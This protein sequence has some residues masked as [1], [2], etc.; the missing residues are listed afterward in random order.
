MSAPSN[1]L[2]R[3]HQVALVIAAASAFV[4]AAAALLLPGF[5]LLQPTLGFAGILA[6]ACALLLAFATPDELWSADA[7]P[8]WRALATSAAALAAVVL[9]AS[10]LSPTPAQTFTFGA[11]GEA[12]GAPTWLAALLVIVIASRQ[13]F[14]PVLHRTVSVAVGLGS[15]S[16]VVGLVEAVGGHQ[17]TGGF[18]NGDYLGMI[19]LLLVPLALVSSRLAVGARR[20]L[21][22]AAAVLMSLAA[23]AG[24]SSAV[25]VALVAE[26][27]ALALFAPQLFGQAALARRAGFV[28]L[29]I[30]LGLGVALTVTTFTAPYLGISA[31]VRDTFTGPTVQ[32][33]LEM[34]RTAY[35]AWLT[36]P[37]LGFGPDG[38]QFAS[39][40]AATLTL[41]RLE[42]APY[43]GISGLLRDPHSLPLM[44]LVS[45]GAIGA[46]A[47]IA[48]AV[49]WGRAALAGGVSSART[50]YVISAVAFGACMFVM[51]WNDRFSALPALVA[52]LALAPLARPATAEKTDSAQQAAAP[53]RQR[54]RLAARLLAGVAALL[55]VTAVAGDML[56]TLGAAA[57]TPASGLPM[58]RAAQAIQPTRAYVR[59]AVLYKEGQGL[60]AGAV[61]FEAY[62]RDVD[63][64]RSLEG[65]GV[66]LALLAQ[67][68]LDLYGLK[69]DP[70]VLAWARDRVDRALVLAPQ[71]PDA[72][73]E[74]AHLAAV[75]ADP[76]TAE[77]L[78]AELADSNVQR[79]RMLLYEYY[80]AVAAGRTADAQKVRA[81][82]TAAAPELTPLL[83]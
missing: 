58:L 2:S 35:D 12:M 60:A 63:A 13:R 4:P 61:S 47:V 52:G 59:Y 10:A 82:L 68:A 38:M 20:S 42:S 28:G 50:A 67:P 81:T 1:A 25:I 65:N 3:R 48:F 23:V 26:W 30:S 24:T 8:A 37:V 76:Q 34:W 56:A 18:G 74:R 70:A 62:R 75:T 46:L 45:V 11:E 41:V 9:V 49:A 66:Y 19:M 72:L 57:R 54:L 69:P 36:R 32:T 40:H 77:E 83:R 55:I 71:N 53:S 27:I 16:A 44:V 64:A 39:Q 17:A 29:G 6:S 73:L 14:A 33:R 80:S 7:G 31:L 15:A 43:T 79:P 22:L 78:L 51:P 5:G 21:F